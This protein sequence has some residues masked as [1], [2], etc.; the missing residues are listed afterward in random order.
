MKKLGVGI[1]GCGAISSIYLKNLGTL[2]PNL[3][4]RAVCDMLPDRAASRAAEFGIA[5]AIALPEL[6][7]SGEIDIVLNL[8]VPKSHYE[9]S[10]A[11]LEAGKHVYSEKPLALSL[12][13][14]E[15]LVALAKSKGLF[16]GVAPDT[17]LGAGLQTCRKLIDEGLIGDV[18]G[19]TAF[20]LDGGPEGWH[21]N[22]AFYYQKGGGPMFDMGPYYIHALVF[23]MGPVISTVGRT[24]RVREVRVATSA[25]RRGERIKVEVPTTVSSFLNFSGG[26]EGILMTS[27]DC[28]GGTSHAPIEIYGSEGT[29]LVPD[30]NTFGGPVRV[31]RKVSGGFEDVALV[32]GYTDNSRGVG[33]SDMASAIVEGRR[34]RAGADLALHALELMVGI[35]VSAAEE[36]KYT[37]RHLCERPDPLVPAS[38]R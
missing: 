16:F 18:F 7:A 6:F 12:P 33:L 26:S 9:I 1:V 4:V 11:A 25:E 29:L 36:D 15:R 22:P 21:P 24:M 20:M 23:L 10:L 30:P 17:M 38:R 34:P 13:E 27:F 32:P 37:M 31:R 5:R 19:A 28:A 35:H 8:T 14:G 2:F 3:E